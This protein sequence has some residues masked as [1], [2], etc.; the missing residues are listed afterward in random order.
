MLSSKGTRPITSMLG[1]EVGL[2]ESQGVADEDQASGGRSWRCVCL[3]AQGAQSQG[4]GSPATEK[5]FAAERFHRVSSLI[6]WIN[7]FCHQVCHAKPGRI[8]W[9]HGMQCDSFV[10]GRFGSAGINE[11][12]PLQN[13]RPP[14]LS[15][16]EGEPSWIGCP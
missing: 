1:I 16:G 13:D 3:Q 8:F 11:T 2:V 4:E 5:G 10:E 9:N 7:T 14:S 15:P 6:T 12:R